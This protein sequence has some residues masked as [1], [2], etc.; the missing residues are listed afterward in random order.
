MDTVKIPESRTTSGDAG[1]SGE[2]VR[3]TGVRPT[4]PLRYRVSPRRSSAAATL[5][6]RA[7]LRRPD[8]TGRVR[9]ELAMLLRAAAEYRS[10]RARAAVYRLLDTIYAIGKKWQAEDRVAA[11]IGTALSLSRARFSAH[12][13]PCFM[14]HEP[15]AIL[16]L[17]IGGI[18]GKTRSKWSR[19]LQVAEAYGAESFEEFAAQYGGIN[20]VAARFSEIAE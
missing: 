11:C 9:T 6:V 4:L 14:M 17:C 2:V 20:E 5:R 1:S 10:T 12:A 13:D 16:I 18:D 3:P 8:P 15:Y 7:R 19:A